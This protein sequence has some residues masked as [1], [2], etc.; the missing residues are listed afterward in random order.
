V[1]EMPLM[2]AYPII[3]FFF[4]TGYAVWWI[5]TCLLIFSVQVPGYVANPTQFGPIPAISPFTFQVQADAIGWPRFDGTLSR[6]WPYGNSS[7][8]VPTAPLNPTGYFFRPTWDTS[9][10][11]CLIIHFFHLL[12]TVQFFIFFSFLTLAG[13]VAN[14]YFTPFTNKKDEN[15]QVVMEDGKAVLCKE[16]GDADN[17]LPESPIRASCCRAFRYNLGTVSLASLIIA[18]IQFIQACILYA[19]EKTKGMGNETVRKIFF[20]LLMAFMKCMECC[21]KQVN[22]NGLVFVAVYGKPF[23][24][25][26]CG[27]FELAL[28]NLGRIAWISMVGDFL[29]GIG[30]VFVAVLTAGICS[31]ILYN[32]DYK[33]Y[34]NTPSF[35]VTVIF[36]LAWGV[37]SMFMVVYE[38][39]IDTIFMC[40]LIDEENNGKKGQKYLAHPDLVKLISDTAEDDDAKAQAEFQKNQG[41][42]PGDAPLASGSEMTAPNSK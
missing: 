24:N 20:C 9:M 27:A 26:T 4:I 30:K 15:G 12:W 1:E 5:Y 33:G 13:A 18:T 7:G 40:F 37:A 29:M 2:V 42:A 6:P 41:K 14:W 19:E 8:I 28:A 34:V 17:Q 22:R 3:P 35:I 16:R 36:I 21:M 10:Q 38:C 32:P 25:S 11:N 31:L 23:C 39:A